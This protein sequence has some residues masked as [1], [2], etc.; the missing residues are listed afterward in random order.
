MFED[1]PRFKI[2]PDPPVAGQPA[3]ITYEGEQESVTWVVVGFGRETSKVPPNHIDIA[4]VPAGDD[5]GVS[6]GSGGPEGSASWPI[7][8][9]SATSTTISTR[10][11]ARE[12]RP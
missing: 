11:Q 7:A 3:R 12:P 4:S 8:T 5:L 10:R 1:K 2:E 9:S 6:D